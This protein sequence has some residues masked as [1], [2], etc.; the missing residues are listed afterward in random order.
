MLSS[1]L[2]SLCWKPAG[3]SRPLLGRTPPHSPP[4]PP[5]PHLLQAWPWHSPPKRTPSPR[6]GH[7]QRLTP[8]G[9][10]PSLI[11]S[12]HLMG[13]GEVSL[14]VALQHDLCPILL[15][16]LSSGVDGRHPL[17]ILLHQSHCP[18]DPAGKSHS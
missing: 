8:R 1:R 4:R 18:G 5:V 12:G 11:T 14:E 3:T 9:R 13:A 6:G 17:M 7:I 10:L 2:R 16:F 15:P